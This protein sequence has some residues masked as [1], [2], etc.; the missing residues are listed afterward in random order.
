MK[1][2]QRDRVDS[3]FDDDEDD[4]DLSALKDDPDYDPDFSEAEGRPKF[5]LR[6]I[7]TGVDTTKKGHHGK[8]MVQIKLKSENGFTASDYIIEAIS[9]GQVIPADWSLDRW[10]EFLHKVG[11]VPFNMLS[12]DKD[13]FFLCIYASEL[14]RVNGAEGKAARDAGWKYSKY[15]PSNWDANVYDP[16]QE[17][18]QWGGVFKED[19]PEGSPIREQMEKAQADK[20]A[21]DTL[22]AQ[23]AQTQAKR[24]DPYLERWKAAERV[25]HTIPRYTKEGHGWEGNLDYGFER[26]VKYC[27]DWIKDVG[28]VPEFPHK[29]EDLFWPRKFIGLCVEEK[30]V[31]RREFIVEKVMKYIWKLAK[32]NEGQIDFTFRSYRRVLAA[33]AL[34]EAIENYAT[35]WKH[36]DVNPKPGTEIMTLKTPDKERIEDV[37]QCVRDYIEAHK[38]VTKQVGTLSTL[39]PSYT[40]YIEICRKYGIKEGTILHE[41]E[42]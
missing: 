1:K 4:F 12:G 34:S 37:K 10:A 22:V 25:A 36:Y 17:G 11:S 19:Y 13:R 16:R 15:V 23:A 8:S 42:L 24:D 32:E 40:Q 39:D 26:M 33:K 7:M 5:S 38:P 14:L 18:T 29:L 27:Y 2:K 3:L 30:S 21:R 31:K 28:S 6:R 20:L 35:N 41:T 9:A